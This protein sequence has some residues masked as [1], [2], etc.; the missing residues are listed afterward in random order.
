AADANGSP[1]VYWL[2]QEFNHTARNLY[3]RI[4]RVTPFIKYVRP[5]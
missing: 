1:A 3:D 5:S 2:T 4:G